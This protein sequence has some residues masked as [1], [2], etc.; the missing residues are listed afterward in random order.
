VRAREDLSAAMAMPE[1]K[2]GATK[3]REPIMASHLKNMLTAR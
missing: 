2:E 3:L 1:I